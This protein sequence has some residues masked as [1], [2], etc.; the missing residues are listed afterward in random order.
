MT[1]DRPT[2][3]GPGLN[4][5]LNRNIH[6]LI[7]ERRAE[8]STASVA[9]RIADAVTRLAGSM[10]FAAVHAVAVLVWIAWN[11]GWLGLR[12][13]DP[14]FVIL[15]TAASVEAIFLSTFILI[16]QNRSAAAADRRAQLDLH[17]SLLAEH[18]I[19]RLLQIAALIAERMSIDVPPDAG[20]DELQRDIAPEKVL[21]RISEADRETGKRPRSRD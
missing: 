6:A 14:T 9:E 1:R 2:D 15:A 4:T 10:T 19:T 11:L 20:L 13:F 8:E 18:E 12:P 17:V 7:D 3:A 5:V 16:S 21:E